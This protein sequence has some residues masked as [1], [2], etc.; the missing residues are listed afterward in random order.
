MGVGGVWR[1]A[2]QKNVSVGQKNVSVTNEGYGRGCKGGGGWVERDMVRKDGG[3]KV[4][5]GC[6]DGHGCDRV[7]QLVGRK[8]DN[9]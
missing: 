1:C 5:W 6:G 9:G 7:A 2:G 3:V 8:D 4:C